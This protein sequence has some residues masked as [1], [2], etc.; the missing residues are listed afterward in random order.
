MASEA[1]HSRFLAVDGDSRFAHVD[2]EGGDP[3]IR[4]CFERE[5]DA[6]AFHALFAM[7]AVDGASR[8]SA[9]HRSKFRS[10]R[11]HASK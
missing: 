11:V 1:A 6:K 10:S 9:K 8:P 7:E 3:V 4:Y 2:E 5:A